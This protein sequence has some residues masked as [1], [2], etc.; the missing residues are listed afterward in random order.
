MR[1]EEYARFDGTALAELIKKREITAAE[2]LEAAIARAE[3]V[4]GKLNL[5]V[6]PMYD[7]ARKQKPDPAAPFA[8]VPLLIKDLLAT[9]AGH[10]TSFGSTYVA[11]LPSPHDSELVARYRRCGL[12]PFAKTNVP[13]LG[14]LPTTEPMAFGPT[15]N[16]FDLDHSPGGSS[17]GSAAGVAA[18]VSPIGHAND[19]GGSI[20]IPAANCG[21]FGLKPT[22]G[23]N[24][25]GPDIGDAAHGLVV[26]HVVTRSVRDSAAV[27][28]QT[29]GLDL[30]APYDAPPR[31]RPFL[32]EVG[33]PVGK[34][35]IAFTTRSVTGVKASDEVTAAVLR[36]A[37]RLEAL[38]H[39]VE[40][41]S[42]D[43]PMQEMLAQA[44]IALYMGATVITLDGFGFLAGRVPDEK[45]F[46]P[47]TWA[48]Y[49]TGKQIPLSQ[50]LLSNG[51]LQRA[52]REIG[53]KFVEHD[54][55]LT[56][57]LTRA[58][59]KIGFFK[60]DP[61]NPLGPLFAAG[62]YAAFTPV[63]NVTGQPAMSVPL[64]TSASGLPLGMHFI[65]RFG[66]EATLLRLAAQ[67]EQ[68]HP[69]VDRLPLT[70][71]F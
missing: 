67:L 63:Q 38:G 40:E 51:L 28:D 19:G 27:L 37:R 11:D 31:V 55:W 45:I 7:D 24:P 5:V 70:R 25:L 69:W 2:V 1:H 4:N 18:G 17:G 36:T 26:E 9:C 33:A 34:L 23:R 60:N 50:Y 61:A 68:A 54:L 49:Q 42:F 20:R 64:E 16:P 8:G 52:A 66:D 58:P 46:E 10:P 35:R 39:V 71:S 3:A 56:P 62:E 29:C 65:G 44:F 57:V 22:R 53:K 47:L 12:V 41:R 6:R 48:M 59:E 13:E 43:F 14:I 21:L 30:G 32:D 15:R